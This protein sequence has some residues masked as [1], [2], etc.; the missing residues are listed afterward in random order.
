MPQSFSLSLAAVDMLLEHGKLGRA[1]FPFQ[2]P[3]IGTTRTQR[4]QVREAVFRD[5]EGRGLMSAGR[6]DGDVELALRT[7]VSSP[8]AIS[9]AAQLEGGKRLFAR[10]VSDGQYAVVAKQ[11][12]N[13]LVFTEARPTGL[14]PA[15]VDLLPL[16]PAA[17]GQSVTIAKAAPPKPRGR[18]AADDGYDPFAGVSPPRS[19]SASQ[20]RYVERIFEKPKLRIG[21]FTAFV[22]GNN[23]KPSDLSPMAWFDTEAGRYFM[24]I[25]DSEDGQ[26]WITYAPAD[27][28][29]IAQHL[30]SQL[31]GYL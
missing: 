11:D 13:L 29:R 21:Q 31:E 17:A 27:N 9:A 22:R 2:V 12:E 8:V 18:H 15:I 14:V 1:P 6:I 19:Q 7:F 23:G 4:A 28:A 24:T 30:Y 5:L 20:M 16:T 25:R 26:T 3:H 10:V